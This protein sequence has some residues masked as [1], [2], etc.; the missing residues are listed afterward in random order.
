MRVE[1]WETLLA[2]YVASAPAFQ[3]GE[4]DCA[5]WTAEWV[6][7]CTGADHTQAWRGKYRTKAGAA[8]LM[9]RRGFTGPEGIAAAHLEEIPAPTAR[10]GDLVLHP[11][12]AL[13]ICT[14]RHSVFLT[15][16]G[17]TSFETLGCGRAWRV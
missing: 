17:I 5:L 16:T 12:G 10:R 13:G 1:G 7:R 8:T 3:W 11:Q 15:E 2:D 4:T 14:G 6:R 9:K